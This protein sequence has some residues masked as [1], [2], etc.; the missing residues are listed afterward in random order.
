MRTISSLKESSD[1][2]STHNHL[3]DKD[4]EVRTVTCDYMEDRECPEDTC[5]RTAVFPC[6]KI[7]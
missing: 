7:L 5:S 4:V 2:D 3:M 6:R 1:E